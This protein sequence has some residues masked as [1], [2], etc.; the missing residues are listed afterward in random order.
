MALAGYEQFRSS[1]IELY[2]RQKLKNLIPGEWESRYTGEG[3]EFA[4]IKPFEP[5]DD[6]RDLDLQTLVQSGEEEIILRVVGRQLKVFLWVDLSGSMQRHRE[7]FFASKPEIRDIVLGLL[8]FS[9]WNAYCPVGLCGFDSEIR[10]FL[11]ARAGESYCGEILSW[12]MREGSRGTQDSADVHKA[13]SF[14][15]AR[16]PAQSLVFFVSDF[17]D[18]AFE[19]DFT[20]WLKPLAKRFDFIPII[21][22]DPLE[23]T[24]RLKRAVSVVL[25]DCEGRG[26]AEVYLTPEKLV[27][28]QAASAKHLE[29]VKANFQQVGLEHIILDSASV[30]ECSRTLEAF[31]LARKRMRG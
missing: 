13:V 18:R 12:V 20:S 30:F 17:Q 25:Q 9:A 22:R 4:S 26:S 28:I 5:G 27:E 24:T 2:T 3:I 15:M 21:I 11:P 31:F 19:G 14:L 16:V 6:L 1:K 7:M 29:H 23:R 8:A 10:N